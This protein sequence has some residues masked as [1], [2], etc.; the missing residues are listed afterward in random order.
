MKKILV[1][2]FVFAIGATAIG[3]GSEAPKTTTPAAKTPPS[4]AK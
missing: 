1:L 2:A 4:A 3:C